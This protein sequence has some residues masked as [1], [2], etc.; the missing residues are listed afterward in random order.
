MSDLE[1]E[2]VDLTASN[3]S[4]RNSE[5]LLD[6]ADLDLIV[7][8]EESEVDED[9]AEVLARLELEGDLAADYL[10]EFLDIV[11]MDGDLDIDVDH[12]RASV[13]II[14]EE[15]D[16][17]LEDLVGEDG[18][19]LDALQELTRLAVQA[20]TGERCRLMLDV[21]GFRAKR[22][23]EIT[24]IA[25]EAIARCQETNKV[26]HLDAMNPF[27]RK[28]VHDLVAAAGLI[29]DSEGV[30]PNRHVL[31]HPASDSEVSLDSVNE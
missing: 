5:K 11:D 21:A 10:E 24:E 20:H 17:D 8:D 26:V 15:E 30:A 6:D 23:A 31:V 25:K 12:G 1:V 29:S 22:R 28:V 4:K 27:E 2:A 9:P 18:H 7:E 19:V 3:E 16:S 13:A 14:T